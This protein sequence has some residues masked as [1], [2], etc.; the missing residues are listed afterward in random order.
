MILIVFSAEP[1]SIGHLA[2]NAQ[3]L[4]TM[5]PMEMM[6]QRPAKLVIRHVK[7]AMVQLIW[8]AWIANTRLEINIT[9]RQVPNALKIV[10][11]GS[12]E[13]MFLRCV[14]HVT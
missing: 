2:V 13:M 6:L 12:T 14:S 7:P 8:I 1:P 11:Q 5:G 4:A 10:V 3:V 9:G